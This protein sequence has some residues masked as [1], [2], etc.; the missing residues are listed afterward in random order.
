MGAD[1]IGEGRTWRVFGGGVPTQIFTDHTGN[2]WSGEAVVFVQ[3][4]DTQ[5]G[6][7]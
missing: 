3:E 5:A 2:A 6:I 4:V 7:G 1:R